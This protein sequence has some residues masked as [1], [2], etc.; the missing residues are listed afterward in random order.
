M[1]A[2]EIKPNSFCKGVER[3]IKIIKNVLDNPLTKKPIYMLGFLVHNRYVVN[4]FEGIEIITS[5][6]EK[7]LSIDPNNLT[8]NVDLGNVNFKLYDYETALFHYLKVYEL[9]PDNK[10]V[11]ICIANTYSLLKN[12]MLD[13]IT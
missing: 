8:A 5:D 1:K 3:A 4:A 2:I 12:K 7:A 11:T 10:T 6:Y 9:A 13:D